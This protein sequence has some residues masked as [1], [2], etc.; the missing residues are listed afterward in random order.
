MSLN[1]SSSQWEKN[2]ERHMYSTDP[3]AVFLIVL[4]IEAHQIAINWVHNSAIRQFVVRLQR[5]S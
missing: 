4:L 5:E 2:L 3:F 1:S